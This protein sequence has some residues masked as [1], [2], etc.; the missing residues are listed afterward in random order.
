MII[1]NGIGDDV[2]I[3]RKSGRGGEIKV[4]RDG[5]RSDVAKFNNKRK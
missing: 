5:G 1:I 3:I 4:W 2:I